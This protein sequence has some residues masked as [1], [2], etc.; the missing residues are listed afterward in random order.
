MVLL[1]KMGIERVAGRASSEAQTKL[2]DTH[3]GCKQTRPVPSE[4]A[5]SLEEIYTG[6]FEGT[7][8]QSSLSK[9]VIRFRKYANANSRISLNKGC[10]SVDISD[11]LENAPLSVQ[12]A[13]ACILV[14]KLFRRAPDRRAVD[15]YRRYLNGTEV[16]RR[17]HATRQAR[18]RKVILDPTG[19]VYDLCWLFEDLNRSYFC[20]LMAR[21][22]LGWSRKRSMSILGHYDP[23]HHAI[24]MNSLLDSCEAPEL[25]V[26]YVLFHE[27]LHLRFPV[28]HRGARRCVHTRE[29]KQAEKEFKNYQEAKQLLKSFLANAERPEIS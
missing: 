21:P 7:G 24:V 27:M 11:V 16:R 4:P 20:G 25:V 10:L 18:G 23:S 5:R 6:V 2:L 15:R 26:R 12:K 28:E 22:V 19:A 13:L 8:S 14:N 17:L 29:F 1:G 9:V 3:S